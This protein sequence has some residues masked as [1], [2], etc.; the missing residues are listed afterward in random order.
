MT[1]RAALLTRTSS[2]QHTEVW[3][4]IADWPEYSVSSL[5]NVRRDVARSSWAAGRLLKPCPNGLNRT[6][7]YVRLSRPDKK[8]TIRLHG[9]VA[10]AFIG[11]RPEGLHINHKDGNRHNN[12]A[13]NLEYVTRRQN[14]DHAVLNALHAWGEKHGMAKL[15]EQNV[16]WIRESLSS[17]RL[18]ADHFGVRIGT[19]QSV[20]AGRTWRHLK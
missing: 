4:Q 7:F 9:L 10:A 1:N 8:Q 11:P 12:A 14:E 19:I 17:N 2:L 3:R 5:G 16:R 6:Y 18:L 20:R 15:T 13:D